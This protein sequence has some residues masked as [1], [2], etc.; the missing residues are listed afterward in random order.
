MKVKFAV[1]DSQLMVKVPDA[2]ETELEYVT[3]IDPSASWQAKDEEE[4]AAI[5]AALAEPSQ[6]TV[7]DSPVMSL[8]TVMARSTE[9]SATAALT[10]TSIAKAATM[11]LSEVEE[12]CISDPQSL[13]ETAVCSTVYTVL[14]PS[15]WRMCFFG[16][17]AHRISRCECSP[18]GSGS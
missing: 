9:L 6:L 7:S 2:P 17:D 12:W 1:L 18:R 15:R 11:D 13:F 3:S 4:P 14:Q 5:V 10:G 8:V 16:V